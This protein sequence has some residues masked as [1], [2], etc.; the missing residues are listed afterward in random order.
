MKTKAI[1]VGDIE[2]I[3]FGKNIDIKWNSLLWSLG[4]DL[5]LRFHLESIPRRYIHTVLALTFL[6]KVSGS[7]TILGSSHFLLTSTQ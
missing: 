6:L 3:I 2:D 4:M 7:A 5:Q 1:E